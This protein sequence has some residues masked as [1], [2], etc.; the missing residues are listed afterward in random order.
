MIANY[1]LSF[2]LCLLECKS[3]DVSELF[4]LFI[5]FPPLLNEIFLN[6]CPLLDSFKKT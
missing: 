6:M 1:A 2:L 4:C 3:Q 5:I